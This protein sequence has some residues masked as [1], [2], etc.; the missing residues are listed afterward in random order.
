MGMAKQ[1]WGGKCGMGDERESKLVRVFRDGD[2]GI[3]EQGWGGGCVMVNEGESK[4]V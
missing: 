2:M 3:A 1:E 4:L